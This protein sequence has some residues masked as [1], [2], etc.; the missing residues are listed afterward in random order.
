MRSTI[1]ALSLLLVVAAEAAVVNLAP[2]FTFIGAG[3]KTRSL[4]SLRGQP[5]VLVIADSP[6]SKALKKQLKN[7]E[8]IY[9]QLAS[10]GVVLVVAIGTGDGPIPS[11]NPVAIA[12]NGAAVAAAYGVQKGFQI[13]IIGR[14]GNLD[15]QTDRVV[16]PERVRDVIQNSFE[17]QDSA[18][19]GN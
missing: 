17:V 6:K 2:E 8:E 19:K 12:S 7:L 5:V 13:A 3:E 9:P 10:K 11:N 14:D 16:A 1:L 18:R 15:Y 4:R